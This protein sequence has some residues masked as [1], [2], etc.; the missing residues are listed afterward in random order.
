[1]FNKQW[2]RKHQ[3]LLLLFANT[4]AGRKI[5]C[6]SGKKSDIGKH[7]IIKI[8]PNYIEWKEGAKYKIEFRTHDKFSK[9]LC[10]AFK[11]IWEAFHWFDMNIANVYAPGL[12]LGFDELTF[13]SVAGA[14][15]PYDGY[16]YRGPVDEVWATIR[17]GAGTAND[18]AT[19]EPLSIFI[20]GSTTNN[21]FQYIIRS[22]TLFDTSDLVGA[23]ITGAVFGYV[24]NA[25][26]NGIGDINVV[27]VASTP[28]S[29]STIANSDY[30]QLGSTSFGSTAY[31]SINIDNS[32]YN[33]ITLSQAGEDNIS[34]D[35]ISKFGIRNHWDQTNIQ[36]SWSS[37]ASSSVS[38]RSADAAGT[39]IDPKLVVTFT[40][41]GGGVRRYYSP[42]IWRE[43]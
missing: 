10:Y 19:G 25:K 34:L 30:G 23:T 16:A 17:A 32:T 20:N 11:P 36:P 28:G 15:E 31:A 9:R 6:I 1:M 24:A 39:S 33:N 29:T 3:K 41:A 22:I 5:L 21:Q 26:S 4:W 12:N 18:S 8:A 37:G 38:I 43:V 14:N 13:Y 42:G 2:F 40:T 7:K 35:G 27:F